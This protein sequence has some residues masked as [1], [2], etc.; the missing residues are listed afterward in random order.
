MRPVYKVPERATVVERVA[1]ASLL[2][3]GMILFFI[4]LSFFGV[5][6]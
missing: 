6:S 5:M 3:R 2:S 4:S 1:V